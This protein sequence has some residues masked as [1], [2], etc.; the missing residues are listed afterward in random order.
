MFAL[1]G[2]A[3]ATSV[4]SFTL[5]ELTDR[6]DFVAHGTVL[7]VKP[8]LTPEGV[9]TDVA[10]RVTERLKG[11]AEGTFQFTTPGGRTAERGTF[12]AGAPVF[13]AGEE[14]VVFLEARGP[15]GLRVPIGLAQ[16]KYTV[17]DEDGRRV[18]VR[19]LAGLRLVDQRTREERDGDEVSERALPLDELLGAVRAR[20]AAGTP[21]GGR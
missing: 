18:A 19:N 7:S 12:I 21:A 10:L 15:K 5:D 16:G 2:V 14:V 6:A 13:E 11:Q 20:V 17:R 8:R 4:L 1:A 3:G 9:V